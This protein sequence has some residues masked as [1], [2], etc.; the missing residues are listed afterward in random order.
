MKKQIRKNHHNTEA[1]IHLDALSENVV[2]KIRNFSHRLRRT[3]Q[4]LLEQSM[5]PILQ[6]LKA[7]IQNKEYSDKI[8]LQNYRY[9]HYLNN[10]DRIVLKVAK[11]YYDETGQVKYHQILL[12]KHLLT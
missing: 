10:L 8:L 3:N 12:P 7:K 9:E 2:D 6:Q 11:P 1:V 4:I 5:D